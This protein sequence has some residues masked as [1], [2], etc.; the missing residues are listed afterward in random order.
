[1]NNLRSCQICGNDEFL[2]YIITKDYFLSQ[3]EF[4]IVRCTNCG[5]LFTYP[6]PDPDELK[7]YYES[8]EYISHSTA[9][10]NFLTKLY[11]YVRKYSIRKK[12]RLISKYTETKNVLDFGCGTGE[13][14]SYIRDQGVTTFGIEPNPSA[15]DFASRKYNLDIYEGFKSL[16]EV[17]NS[18]DAVTLWHSLEHV[19]DLNTVIS[20]IKKVIKKEGIVVVG[21]PNFESKD[22]KIYGKYWSAYD[23]PRHLYHFNKASISKLFDKHGFVMIKT[24][25]MSFDAFYVSLLSEKYKKGKLNYFNAFFSGLRSNLAAF[26]HNGEYSSIIYI[27]ELNE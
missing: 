10:K 24:H 5:F 27:F 23:V 13:F 6:R 8:D 2:N 20:N 14:L 25:P 26:L 21:I 4:S 18:F 7:K 3:K 19:D 9:K 16:P 11:L 1:M 12:A 15:R 17:E 22:A